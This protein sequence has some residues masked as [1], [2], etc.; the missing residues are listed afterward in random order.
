MSGELSA[1]EV[2]ASIY[3][4][5]K[6][7]LRPIHEKLMELIMGFGEFEIVPKKTYISLRRARQFAMI[8]PATNT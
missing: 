3:S 5:A 8:G 7:S 4:G 1:D 2:L 6:T